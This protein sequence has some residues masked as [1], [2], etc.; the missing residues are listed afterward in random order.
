MSNAA[1]Q[2]EFGERRRRLLSRL[3]ERSLVWLPAAPELLRNPDVHHPYRQESNF[4]YLCGFAQSHCSLI[5]GQPEHFG[6]DVPMHLFVRPRVPKRELWEGPRAGLSEAQRDTAATS[7]RSFEDLE[8]E[9]P[10]LLEGIDHLYTPLGREGYAGHDALVLRLLARVRGGR[11]RTRNAGLSIGDPL[12]HLAEL[13]LFKSAFEV[14]CLERAAQISAVAHC[15]LMHEV[16]PGMTEVQMAALFECEVRSRGAQRLAYPSIVA[17]GANATYMHYVELSDWL[18]S[19]ELLLVDAGGEVDYYAAD[20]TRT[21]PI[22]GELSAPQRELYELTLQAQEAALDLCQVGQTLPQIHR[23]AAEVLAEGLLR[24][25]LLVGKGPS[26]VIQN[27]QLKRFCPHSTSHWLGLDVHDVGGYL[28]AGSP[29]QSGLQPR[30]LESGMVFTVEPGVYIPA[31][32]EGVPSRYRGIGIRIEDSVLITSA[33]PRNLTAG[34]PK[35]A[36]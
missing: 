36:P 2:A 19:G 4:Y 28:L 14:E 16:K 10:Q 23:R 26:E 7:V 25:G 20:I 21:Y 24:L 31:Q 27:G 32:E 17:A 9:M 12:P 34:V 29:P 15:R 35:N 22:D 11:A 30:S 13:R 5:I 1:L 18:R 6:Q 33:G 8:W 3:P